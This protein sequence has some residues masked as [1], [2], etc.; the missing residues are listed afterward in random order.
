[1]QD[2][3]R[4]IAEAISCGLAVHRD[5][6]PGLLESVYEAFLAAEL[7][8]RGFEVYRQKPMTVTRRGITIAEG[9]RLDLLVNKRLIIEVKS[10]ER[11]A[12]VHAKQLLTYLRLSDLPV[13]LLMNFGAEL[14]KDGLKRVIDPA[15]SY[16]APAR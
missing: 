13:G 12:P 16:R 10:T 5:L 2:L 8:G 7:E 1:M 11:F 3:E 15:N 14:F 6:G 9:F 4:I